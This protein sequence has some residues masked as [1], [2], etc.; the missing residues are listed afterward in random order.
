MPGGETETNYRP[1]DS[2]ASLADMFNQ[3]PKLGQKDKPK[4][5][6][7]NT[8]PD[9]DLAKINKDAEKSSPAQP[10]V[11]QRVANSKSNELAEEDNILSKSFQMKQK[12]KDD[13][14]EEK[15]G[16]LPTNF[17]KIEPDQSDMQS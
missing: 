5:D 14:E 12:Q 17:T 7:Q 8:V 11:T 3:H 9:I 15:N 4:L 13:D 16:D 1:A 2:M 10:A 6:K